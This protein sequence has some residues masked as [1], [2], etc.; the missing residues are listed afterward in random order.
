[1]C[2]DC[3]PGFVLHPSRLAEAE[4]KA[5]T[6]S[7][8]ENMVAQAGDGKPPKGMVPELASQ[9][10]VPVNVAF[11]EVKR[12]IRPAARVDSG[13]KT[14]TRTRRTAGRRKK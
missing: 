14:R 6:V 7:F 3:V 2:A 4:V 12:M 5:L 10:E 1:M 11:A 9:L 8:L 13:S